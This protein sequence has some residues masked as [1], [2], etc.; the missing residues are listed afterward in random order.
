MLDYDFCRGGLWP[1]SCLFKAFGASRRAGH[2]Y[3]GQHPVFTHLLT[4]G[5]ERQLLKT[6]AWPPTPWSPKSD[7]RMHGS[8]INTAI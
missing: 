1:A 7:S 2:R 4:P 3:S 6:D 8:P 5:V